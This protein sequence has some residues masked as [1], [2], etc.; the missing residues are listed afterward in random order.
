[1]D[2]QILEMDGFEAKRRLLASEGS[3]THIPVIAMTGN[4]MSSD[5]A[6]CLDAGMDGYVSEPVTMVR[7]STVLAKWLPCEG[8]QPM[9]PRLDDTARAMT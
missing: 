2:C 8:P 9:D 4:A 6:R 5:R 3:D 7:L 1:M